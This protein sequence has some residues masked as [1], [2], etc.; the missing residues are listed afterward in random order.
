MKLLKDALKKKEMS[1]EIEDSV[2]PF[3]PVEEILNKL[4]SD[5]ENPNEAIKKE[6]ILLFNDVSK[7]PNKDMKK[8]LDDAKVLLGEF[9]KT[10][11]KPNMDLI[12]Q[13]LSMLVVPLT[14]AKV[15]ENQEASDKKMEQLDESS[16]KEKRSNSVPNSELSSADES[17]TE[18][19]SENG[20]TE[21]KPEGEDKSSPS[22]DKKETGNK[23][24]SESQ[25]AMIGLMMDEI[26]EVLTITTTSTKELKE[27]GKKLKTSLDA[28]KE[29]Q[30][31]LRNEVDVI[32]ENLSSIES[33]IEKFIGL[34]EVVS[35]MYNPFVAQPSK[36]GDK[37]SSKP[38]P[39]LKQ[40]PDEVNDSDSEENF[41]D[42]EIEEQ[43]KVTK[44]ELS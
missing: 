24:M 26:K 43:K 11:Q 33:N 7:N 44:K 36:S 30:N 37:F 12:D 4:V 10:V 42:K 3:S 15:K 41:F 28:L 14:T 31:A 13:Y 27:D 2:K 21:S 16:V 40:E 17:A 38:K 29:E 34:Y 1:S 6:L 35:N 20:E 25:E 22:K 8:V 5:V 32:K 9:L 39:V 19:A 18:I 23:G